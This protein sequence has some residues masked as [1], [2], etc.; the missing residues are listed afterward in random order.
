[1]NKNQKNNSKLKIKKI[2]PNL[3]NGT[4]LIEKRLIGI[5]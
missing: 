4:E 3:I 5:Q 2:I 1:M